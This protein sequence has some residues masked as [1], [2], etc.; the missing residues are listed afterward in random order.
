MK[1]P[2]LVVLILATALSAYSFEKDFEITLNLKGSHL[3]KLILG[4]N[5]KGSDKYDRGLDDMAPPQG[6]ETGYSSLISPDKR[7][8]LYKDIRGYS[9]DVIWFLYSAQYKEKPLIVSWDTKSVPPGYVMTIDNP[10]KGATIKNVDMAKTG[11]VNIKGKQ[12][13]VIRLQKKAVPQKKK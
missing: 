6:I 3:A 10:D 1:T 7:F 4:C 13:L 11:K 9:D 5:K 2:C 12:T 8:Y